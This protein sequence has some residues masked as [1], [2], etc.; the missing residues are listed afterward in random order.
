[1]A[2]Q[3]LAKK[4]LTRGAHPSGVLT[5][6]DVVDDPVAWQAMKDTFEALY[7]GSKNVGKTAFLNGKWNFHKLGLSLPELVNIE[8]EKWSVQQ[9]LLSMGV[10][11]SVAGLDAS[12]NYATA[13][14][15]ELNFRKYECLSQTTLI[16]SKL[17]SPYNG[18][19]SASQRFGKGNIKI[20][21]SMNGLID[22]E[23]VNKECEPMVR[24]G[25]MT[26]NEWRVKAGLSPV[27][28]PALDEYYVTNSLVPLS[29][30]GMTGN[31]LPDQ[32]PPMVK[33]TT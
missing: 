14:T 13:R 17:N 7:A 22:L 27:A 3:D 19:L 24:N 23:A 26:P 28:D 25:A 21:Y 33:P 4:Y 8:A 31:R 32:V 5:R 6:E 20:D 16:V 10:P 1:M 9:I 29:M 11:L 30:S 18:L 2:V 15:D 12:A